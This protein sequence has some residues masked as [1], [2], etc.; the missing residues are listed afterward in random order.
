MD[1]RRLWALRDYVAE[2]N[3]ILSKVLSGDFDFD[4]LYQ[5][6]LYSS[7]ALQ[8]IESELASSRDITP[9]T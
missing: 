7:H 8:I 4:D 6:R 9:D 2:I 1:E 3:A 5:A